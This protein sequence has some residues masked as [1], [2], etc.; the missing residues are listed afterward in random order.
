MNLV[1]RNGTVIEVTEGGSRV[2][3]PDG[4]VIE[5]NPQPDD[6]YRDT[7]E[8]LGYGGD[9]LAMCRDH[10]PLHAL[11]TDWLGLPASFSLRVAAGLDQPNA[12]AGLEEEAVLALQKFVRAAGLHL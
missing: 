6:E 2:T 3:L 11:L 5:G 7:A 12:L 4:T 1:C 8:W 10:D 9:T